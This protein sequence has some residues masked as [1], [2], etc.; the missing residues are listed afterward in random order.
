[1]TPL[2]TLILGLHY[3]GS[4]VAAYL[5][6]CVLVAAAALM[7]HAPGA[8]RRRRVRRSPWQTALRHGVVRG[9]VA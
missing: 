6:V 3:L 8:V 5:L 4:A 2:D 1:M 9:R 7:W